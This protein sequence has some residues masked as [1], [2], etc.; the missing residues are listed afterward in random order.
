M[1]RTLRMLLCLAQVLP[2]VAA[3]AAAQD[4]TS[5]PWVRESM[6]SATLGEERTLLVATP[7]GYEV[8]TDSF[9]VLVL[10]DADD[11][12]QFEAA[13]ANAKFLASRN[14]I[15]GLIIVGITNGTDRTRDMTPA[16]SGATAE[17]VPTAGGAAAFQTFIADEVLPLIRGKY[18]SRP[19]TILA[20]HSFGGLFALDVAATG[21]DPYLGIIAMSPSLWW[22]DSAVVATYADALARLTGGPRLFVTS[23]AFEGAID[24]PTRH[25]I[26]RLDSLTPE[27]ISYGYLGLPDASHGLTPVPSLMAGLRFVFE[28]I[29]VARL[30]ISRI[31]PDADSA[32]V[33]NAVRESEASYV[34]GARS[35]SLPGELPE[36]L[37]NSMAYAALQVL[38]L[39]T[40]AVWM[41]AKNVANHP[42][43]PNVYDSYGDGLAAAG[44]TTAAIAQYRRAVE[45]WEAQHNPLASMSR[46]KLAALEQAVKEPGPARR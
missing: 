42:G 20:G 10:L 23:G 6:M 31:G 9:P 11:R 32:A 37:V 3:Q 21:A 24:R 45:L 2:V 28:P 46:E 8:G 39:P 27:G 30:P 38:K 14:E 43:S 4:S 35:L 26:A 36:G 25:F 34:R 15:P 22:N 29:S 16:A 18:R 44:D 5:L 33:V 41:F 1:S 12:P 7:N 40:V 19:T 13:I 17:Q